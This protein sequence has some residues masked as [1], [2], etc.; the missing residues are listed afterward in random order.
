MMTSPNMHYYETQKQIKGSM[1]LRTQ[2]ASR[3]WSQDIYHLSYTGI[4][5]VLLHF[6]LYITT[7]KH[8]PF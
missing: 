2:K 8:T 3:D 5:I 7:R 1:E 6:K 4:S